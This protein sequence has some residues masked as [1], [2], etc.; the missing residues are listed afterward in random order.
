LL[1]GRIG[2]WLGDGQSVCLGALIAIVYL[3]IYSLT[4]NLHWIYVASWFR[5]M[6]DVII[7]ASSYA[8][9]SVLIPPERRGFLFGLFNATLFLSWGVAGT[10]IAGPIVDL[11]YHSGISQA[12][13]YR[14]AYIS[15]LIMVIIGLS[16]QTFLVFSL[17]P[18]TE[19]SAQRNGN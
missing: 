15:G 10:L 6:A 7:L 2:R 4:N 17:M 1:A 3:L 18:K 13:A 8:F 16:I 5:G 9:V 12:I 19:I 14:A 11:L